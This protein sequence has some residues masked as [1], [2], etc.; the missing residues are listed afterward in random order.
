LLECGGVVVGGTLGEVC[1]FVGEGVSDGSGGGV[2]V[3]V[4][5]GAISLR[6]GI[7]CC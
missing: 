1:G 5:E 7:E 2:L 4:I 6:W 3:L